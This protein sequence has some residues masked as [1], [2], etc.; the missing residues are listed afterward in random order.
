MIP[1]FF[2]RLC[3]EHQAHSCS[4]TCITFSPSASRDLLEAHLAYFS[5]YQ[6]I[7][8]SNKT[9]SDCILCSL[10][11]QKNLNRMDHLFTRFQRVKNPDQTQRGILSLS[12]L[13]KYG[14]CSC[15]CC[16]K[17]EIETNT[18]DNSDFGIKPKR[19]F[20]FQNKWCVAYMKIKKIM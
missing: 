16:A 11:L 6:L 18:L 17:I 1:R 3:N 10:L 9:N 20:E 14:R 2:Q 12:G 4:K 19:H 7:V 15:N 5:N 13:L 8:T